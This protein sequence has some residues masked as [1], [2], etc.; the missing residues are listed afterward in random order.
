MISLDFELVLAIL[1]SLPIVIV[2][3]LSLFYTSS[4][5]VNV[6]D[7]YTDLHQCPYCAIVFRMQ[8]DAAVTKCP[9][10]KSIIDVG[11]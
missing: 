4:E 8:K 7:E 10:C 5:E 9:Q 2:F 1:L 6:E 3:F 11:G